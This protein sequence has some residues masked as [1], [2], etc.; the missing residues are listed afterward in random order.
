V[1][2]GQR[3]LW[4]RAWVFA[5]NGK[6][7]GIR[8]RRLGRFVPI[9]DTD[10]EHAFCLL[11][12]ALR[13]GFRAYPSSA[14]ALRAAIADVGAEIGAGGTF[15]FLLGD[16]EQLY[17]R[18]DTRLCYIIRQAPFGRATLA[19]QDVSVDFSAVT[20]PHDRVAI[21]ATAPLTRD[22]AWTQGTPGT[23]WVFRHGK[24]VAAVPSPTRRDRSAAVPRGA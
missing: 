15:N 21:V 11:L 23:L 24:M 6:V 7:H 20:T 5:H 4:G 1:R 3:E 14:R 10:S 9:G 22:E 13:A 16:G 8:R 12:E 17:A 18:C 2:V 19:D